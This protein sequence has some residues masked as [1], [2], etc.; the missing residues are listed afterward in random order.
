VTWAGW[1]DGFVSLVA[2]VNY[3]DARQ[4]LGAG[5]QLETWW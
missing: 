3:G 5:V 2:P 1:S 4:G